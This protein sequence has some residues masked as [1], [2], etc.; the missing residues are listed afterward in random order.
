M[1][2]Q[3]ITDAYVYLLSRALVVRQE[4]IDRDE[5]GFAYNQVKYNPLGSADF[6]NPNFD[7][8]YLEGWIAVD[9]DHPV[10]LEVPKVEGRYYT[11]QILDE[12]GEV[13]VNIN[14]RTF[15]S[16]PFGAFALTLPGSS[17]ALPAGATRIDLH[18]SKAKLLARVELKGDP[19]GALTLQKQFV[20]T[21][22]GAP[23]IAEPPQ[24]P[25][26]SNQTLIGAELF[27]LAE[28]VFASALDVS[29]H[30]AQ[31]QQ[32][33][34]AVA[35]HIASSDDARAA[36][37]KQIHGQI[38]P[39]FQEFA[40]TKS[41]PQHE[42]WVGGAPDMGNYGVNYWLRATV[43]YL[44]IWAN[45][46]EEVIYFTTN[47]DALGQRLD[48]GKGYVIHF[49]PDQLPDS[50][51]DA[52]WSVILVDAADFRV[53][54]NRLARF[55]LNNQSPLQKEADGSLKIAIGAMPVA[56]VPEANWLPSAE[57]KAYSLTFRA[58]VPKEVVK[59]GAWAPPG[60]APVA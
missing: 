30:A 53:V 2:A 17:P 13:I 49:P 44:G 38:V 32:Q 3:T 19:T 27:D 37:D 26:F 50:V 23:R 46:T 29:P 21:A 20:L 39:A 40:F 36:A 43:N 15:P 11:A 52:Y 58:Y 10:V 25:P 51:V 22:Q 35:V 8:A 14:E 6:V 7:V 16:K 57:G 33:V 34:R 24:M 9:A 31:M 1:D 56:G 41:A 42:G 18:S 28:A 45:T 48:G 55:N 54:P 5:E 4:H 47:R 60:L 59:Q 12:W